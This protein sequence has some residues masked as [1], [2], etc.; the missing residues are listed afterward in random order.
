MAE[1]E[2]VLAKLLKTRKWMVVLGMLMMLAG[3]T[4]FAWSVFVN[5]LMEVRGWSRTQVAYVGN[6]EFCFYCIG[7]FAAGFLTNKI[8]VKKVLLIGAIGVAVSLTL[9]AMAPT[10]ML[11][12]VT[13]GAIFGTSAGMIYSV[14]MF[15]CGKWWPDG[16]AFAMALTLCIWGGAPAFLG[17]FLTR[18]IASVGVLNVF[19]GMA[20]FFGVILLI[21]A[22]LFQAPPEDF[23]PYPEKVAVA[24]SEQRNY[25]LPQAVR[26]WPF[27]AHFIAMAIYPG[28]YMCMNSLLISFGKASGFSETM[29]AMIVTVVALAQ[30]T[31]RF[32][33]GRVVDKFGWK[34]SYLTHYIIFMLGGV[35]LIIF[36]H[37]ATMIF[38]AFILIGV[39]FGSVSV[40]NP[41][42]GMET[43]GPK[44]SASVFGV[45]LLGYAPANLILPRIGYYLLDTTGSYVPLQIFAMVMSTIGALCALSIKGINPD[46]FPVEASAKK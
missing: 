15:S 4:A 32:A 27:W 10:P 46:K 38:L 9:S 44:A 43:W 24:P 11:M 16:K 20:V 26:T 29:A 25:Y 14:A 1:N 45:A 36:A 12:Y 5:P 35:M 2:Q 30:L 7:V 19:Y 22:A 34:K 28:L 8:G 13:Y 31:G 41:V 17:P 23:N 39:G 33:W 42:I 40:T 6:V 18:I 37:N 3:S 21:C